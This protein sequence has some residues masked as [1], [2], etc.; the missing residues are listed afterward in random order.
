MLSGAQSVCADAALWRQRL[1]LPQRFFLAASRFIAKKNLI[2]LLDA[3]AA[4]RQRAGADAWHLVLLGDGELRSEVESRIARPD[5]AGPVVLAGFK[6]YDE[7]PR[8]Y[9][10]ASAFVHASTTEQWG[11]VVNE[12]MAS[13]LPV[14]VSN[15]CGCAPDL[16]EDGVNGFTFDP[17]DVQALAGLMQRVAAMTDERRDAMRRAGQRIIA[18]WGPERFADGLMRAAE[19]AMRRPLP[20]PSW[21]DQAPP[22]GGCAPAAVK[23]GLLTAH[24][25]RRA[26]GV[27]VSVAQLGKALAERG[28]DVEIFGLADDGTETEGAGWDGPPLSLHEVL[29]GEAFGYAP[30]L[31]RSLHGRSPSLL[32]ANGLW[33]YPSLASFRWSRRARRP[34]LVAPHGMLDPWAVSHAV[35]KKRLVGLVVRERASRGRL[36][37]ARPYGSRGACDQSVRPVQSDLRRP[38]RHRSAEDDRRARPAWARTRAGSEASFCSWVGC[39]RRRAWHNLLRAWTGGAAESLPRRDWMLVIAGWDQGGHERRLERIAEAHRVRSIRSGSS[40]PSSMTTRRRASP[41]P[42]RSSCPR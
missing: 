40:G 21:F 31:A 15:R 28:L 38:E 33:M 8:Y 34:Y 5:L 2:R 22:V 30:R 41:A 9:G 36:L 3:Y 13:G 29:G 37:P 10:L 11:L 18:D 12:A 1:G 42:M 14:L 7:L 19:A 27:W 6:Q 35:W 32:H 20:R 23:I 16:V 17:Y 4:Y 24:A 39:I 26:A 25:S